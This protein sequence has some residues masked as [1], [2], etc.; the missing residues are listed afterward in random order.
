MLPK[1]HFLLGLAIS[2]VLLILFPNIGLISFLVIWTSSVLIDFDHYAYYVFKKKDF[3]LRNARNWFF[4]HGEK[5][6]SI[7]KEERKEYK[8]VILVFHGIEF[9]IFL[10]ILSV[11]NVFF[12]YILFGVLIHLFLDYAHSIY[13]KNWF[14]RKLSQIYVIAR[15]RNKKV[16][17]VD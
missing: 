3:S 15:N 8:E 9:I 13:Y 1:Y 2:L 17:E 4:R 12:S 5:I 11:I 14:S 10:V 6:D 7:K 16:L